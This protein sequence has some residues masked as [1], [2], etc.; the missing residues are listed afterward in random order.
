MEKKEDILKKGVSFQNE[1]QTHSHRYDKK[2]GINDRESLSIRLIS[3]QQWFFIRYKHPHYPHSLYR[4]IAN[5]DHLFPT[6][7]PQSIRALLQK[8]LSDSPRYR[9]SFGAASTHICSTKENTI[10]NVATLATPPTKAK[11]IQPK[12]RHVQTNSI[13]RVSKFCKACGEVERNETEERVHKHPQKTDDVGFVYTIEQTQSSG[14]RPR[15][16][17]ERDL[18]M[19]RRCDFT[20]AI[21]MREEEASSAWYTAYTK[22]VE[23][24]GARTPIAGK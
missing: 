6:L 2:K 21:E 22:A 11:A 12:N 3:Y 5:N 4:R 16:C 9:P 15:R 8:S 10:T 18:R 7:H 24:K 13:G 23:Q 20:R 1:E 14:H 19:E 17:G